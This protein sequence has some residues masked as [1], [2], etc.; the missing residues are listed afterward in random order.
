MKTKKMK[1]ENFLK[2]FQ[3]KTKG[4]TLVEL[5]IVITILSILSVIAFVWFK[6]YSKGSRDANKLSTFKNIEKGLDLFA[7]KTGS[8]PEPEWEVT[9]LLWSGNILLL[10]KWILWETISQQIQANK[11]SKDPLTNDYYTYAITE[12]KQEFQLSTFLEDDLVWYTN[13]LFSKIYANNNYKAYVIWNY[14]PK[15]FEAN[16]VSYFLP[17][18]IFNYS[19]SI[20]ENKLEINQTNAENI[21]YVVNK[22]NNLPYWGNGNTQVNNI[23]T[24]DLSYIKELE[25]K[26]L[27]WNE[28]LIQDLIAWKITSEITPDQKEM[29]KNIISSPSQS[30]NNIV[31]QKCEAQ[32]IDDYTIWET[33]HG[34]NY[35]AE[36]QINITNGIQV[37]KQIFT[38][39]D[40]SFE[41][42][43]DEIFLLPSCD[44]NYV[45]NGNSCEL[46]TCSWERPD[47]SELNGTQGTA[48]WAWSQ[49][50]AWICKYKC[51]DGYTHQSWACN[52]ITP[53]TGWSF[54]INSWASITNIAGVTL[55]I[56]CPSDVSNPIQVAYGNTSNPT[57]WTTCNSWNIS[58]TLTTWDGNKTVYV[59]FRD[60]ATSQNITADVTKNI[61]L[62]SN[63]SI[64][65]SWDWYRTWSD[66]T[67][68]I[69]CNGYRNPTS[70][71]NY[72]W[73]TWNGTYRIDPD[74]AWPIAAFNV[75]CDMTDQD[76]WWTLIMR[77]ASDSAYS[78]TNSVWVNNNVDWN[79]TDFN[80]ATNSNTKWNSYNTVPGNNIKI[81][82]YWVSGTFVTSLWSNQTM[83]QK[84]NSWKQYVNFDNFA[85]FW[86][87]A[88]Y[89]NERDSWWYPTY[90]WV[91]E[92][93]LGRVSDYDAD[94]SAFCVGIWTAQQWDSWCRPCGLTSAD[95][96][97]SCV[98]WSVYIK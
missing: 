37:Y 7:L 87:G 80:L 19:G 77:F 14:K 69:S 30:A 73:N 46:D 45:A 42:S 59:R 27:E 33:H 86:P 47:N 94:R 39:N 38:C 6:D 29:I 41:K 67:F 20:V 91:Y 24:K 83:L 96:Y 75:Y 3:G 22:E 65:L 72:T 44:E 26:L 15:I 60:S 62:I 84:I 78:Y 81:N 97:A 55:N 85:A 8:Y 36:K 49:E 28:N 57:N 13:L 12:N 4:F 2:N 16:G 9:E 56:T 61:N 92:A 64:L 71:Y 35:N 98:Q 34:N 52:D 93:R 82:R 90:R 23:K 43:G 17:S 50:E 21:Y 79:I 95:S 48:S 76:G 54:T 1:S 31:F 63:V 51:S 66:G 88:I 74:G 18:L 58:H 89:A 10:K 53:P 11:T 70:P 5:I 32:E 68:A 25:N 40:G